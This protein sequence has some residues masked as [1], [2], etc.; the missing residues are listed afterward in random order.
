MVSESVGTIRSLML[1]LGSSSL[2]AVVLDEVSDPYRNPP[3]P[4]WSVHKNFSAG[5]SIKD[6]LNALL[7]EFPQNISRVV[8]RV[9]HGGAKFHKTT[10]IDEKV[11]SEIH[12]L[13]VFAPLHNPRALELINIAEKLFQLPHFAAF[14]TA[15]F[16]SMP[17]IATA[18]ALP[19]PLREAGVRRYGFHGLSHSY[20]LHRVSA[21][22]GY[23]PKRLL[24]FHLGSGCS[25]SAISDGQP[26][27]CSMGFTPLEGLV[28]GTRSGSI[29]PGIVLHLC[30][31]YS[32]ESVEQLL[33]SRSGLFGVSEVSG[34]LREVISAMSAGNASAKLAYDLFIRSLVM[35]A[36]S[37]YALLGGVDV[38]VFT[39]GIGEHQEKVRKE[40]LERCAFLPRQM[41][42]EG[43]VALR[44]PCAVVIEAREEIEMGLLKNAASK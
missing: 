16:T 20:S 35:H 36:G 31:T 2:K 24:V 19:R 37:A 10:L 17:E 8:H 22:L 1:N 15:F 6:A 44:A 39:G 23:T 28:M 13:S 42:D 32:V 18:Y 9:V 4:V 21:L 34:D 38:V 5:E 25:I 14:D 30:K 26:I 40:V 41:F 27:H 29:D 3:A 43:D 12:R 7:S 33:V 11:K